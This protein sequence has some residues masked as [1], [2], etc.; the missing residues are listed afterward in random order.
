MSRSL[1]VYT[2]DVLIGQLHERSDIWCFE[3]AASW[4]ESGT[5]DLSPFI[6]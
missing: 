5:F 1:N 2:N 6:T 4:I 3:Y